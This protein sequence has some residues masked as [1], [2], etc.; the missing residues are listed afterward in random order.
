MSMEISR[1]NE[2]RLRA[3]AQSEGVTVD[4]Y[5]E[6]LMNEREEL[7]GIL[8]RSIRLS[9]EEIHTKIE[10][11]VLES[12]QGDVVDGETFSTGLLAELDDIE[13]KRRAG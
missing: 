1:K 2:A 8:A 9:P 4:A 7:A 13:H 6:R 12:E 11:G 3:S 10:R 5:V